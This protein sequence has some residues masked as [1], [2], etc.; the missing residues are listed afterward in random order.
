MSGKNG[1]RESSETIYFI[2]SVIFYQLVQG[3]RKTKAVAKNIIYNT[4]GAD[5]GFSLGGGGGAKDYVHARTSRAAKPKF[6]TSG[7]L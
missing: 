7:V 3:K 6:L 1:A 2:K 4:T 5:P